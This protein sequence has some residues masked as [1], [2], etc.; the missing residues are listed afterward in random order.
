MKECGN[1]NILDNFVWNSMDWPSNFRYRC[2][3]EVMMLKSI[4]KIVIG[5]RR[6][7]GLKF[8]AG[9]AVETLKSLRYT[10]PHSSTFCNPFLD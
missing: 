1:M 5:L 9:N 2:N 8:C 6:R 10:R 7:G 3:L 4:K